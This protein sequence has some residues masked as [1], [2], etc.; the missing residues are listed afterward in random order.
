ML[1]FPEVQRVRILTSKDIKYPEP[2]IS[3]DKG[4]SK[5]AAETPVN[6][7]GDEKKTGLPKFTSVKKGS[8]MMLTV[9]LIFSLACK[10]F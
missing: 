10:F 9:V 4:C 2:Q 5:L 1:F 6:N 7:C 3:V 8:M